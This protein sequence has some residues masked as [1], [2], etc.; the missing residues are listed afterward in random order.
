MAKKQSPSLRS[1]S[2][3]KSKSAVLPLPASTLNV[4][5]FPGAI[6]ASLLSVVIF[7]SAYSV[8]GVTP[9]REQCDLPLPPRGLLAALPAEHNRSLLWGTY[10]PN[11]YFGIR[12]RTGPVAVVAGLMWGFRDDK[13]EL[14]MRHQCQ[15][16]DEL[17]R[18]GWSRH[19][20]KNFGVQATHV[21]SCLALVLS[22]CNA[23]VLQEIEDKHG[24]VQLNTSFVK[25]N[26]GSHGGD[27]AAR[28]EGPWVLRLLH[29]MN[30][31][32]LRPVQVHPWALHKAVK[33]LSFSM[34]VSSTTLR[35]TKMTRSATHVPFRGGGQAVCTCSD[36]RY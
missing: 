31:F 20:G 3:A 5:G 27:W 6:A 36:E 8:T 29:C 23:L 13:G 12:S 1:P 14:V 28:I 15:E 30:L 18:Y 2:E 16:S 35:H 22:V 7:Y 11:V 34:L 24:G 19:D 4:L 25:R 33:C 26:G 9:S 17:S 10:R 21:C 32:I